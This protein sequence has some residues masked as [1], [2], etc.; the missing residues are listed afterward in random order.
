VVRAVA[1]LLVVGAATASEVVLELPDPVPSRQHLPRHG[2]AGKLLVDGP[3]AAITA[4]AIDRPEWLEIEFDLRSQRRG[5]LH[6]RAHVFL[7]VVFSINRTGELAIPPVRVDFANGTSSHGTATAI[8][9]LPPLAYLEDAPAAQ[10]L[11]RPEDLV[12]GQEAELH[13]RFLRPPGLPRKIAIPDDWNPPWPDGTLT[14]GEGTSEQGFVVDGD[15][16]VWRVTTR[17]FIFAPSEAGRFSIGG[18]VPYGMERGDAYGRRIFHRVGRTALRP[19][20]YAVRPVPTAE[21][22][23]DYRGLV[24]EVVLRTRLEHERI[25]AGEGTRLEVIVRHDQV[26]LIS[27]PPAIPDVEGL[28]IYEID[29]E[30]TRVG[31]RSRK[32]VFSLIPHQAGTYRIPSLSLAWFDFEDEVFRRARSEPLSLLVLPG[33]ERDFER[34][35]G[36]TRTARGEDGEIHLPTPVRDGPG[37]GLPAAIGWAALLAGAVGG[38]VAGLAVEWRRRV[39]PAPK[40]G[41][42]LARH[43]RR[44]DPTAAAVVLQQALA[45]ATDPELKQT[46]RRAQTIVDHHRFGGK[47]PDEEERRFLAGL[48]RRL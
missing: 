41:R 35:G 22:P 16:R 47:E 2:I 9:V 44:G 20:S 36:G 32:F 18:Q 14:H 25:T 26:G 40:F 48:G 42:Q 13:L 24:G 21:A 19:A 4:V 39:R 6:G 30:H 7:D 29:E 17:V 11:V 23:P 43:L 15:G 28:T 31:D 8:Q 27:E 34:T 45:H 3:P 38:L 33:R 10:A 5:V 46:I 1:L 37:L 12:V